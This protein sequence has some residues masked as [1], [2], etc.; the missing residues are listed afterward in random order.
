MAKRKNKKPLVTLSSAVLA[1]LPFADDAYAVCNPTLISA[2]LLSQTM[3]WPTMLACTGMT[4]AVTVQPL[5]GTI[6]SGCVGKVIGSGMRARVRV[7]GNQAAAGD[8]VE[9]KIADNTR[10]VTDDGHSLTVKNFLFA[11]SSSQTT[12]TQAGDVTVTYYIGA[13]ALLDS[14]QVTGSYVGTFSVIA[15]CQ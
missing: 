14:S 3:K 2:T 15:D 8:I 11:G 13:K 6:T 12:M 5:G 4:G 1:L 10:T 9:I 7:K